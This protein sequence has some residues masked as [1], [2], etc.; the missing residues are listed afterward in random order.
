MKMIYSM[1][2]GTLKNLHR[3]ETFQTEGA[4]DE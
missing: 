2:I 3:K 1:L 4:S